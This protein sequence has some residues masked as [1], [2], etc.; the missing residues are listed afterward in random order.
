MKYEPLI[1]RAVVVSLVTAALQILNMVGLS[2]PGQPEEVTDAVFYVVMFVS[3]LYA[4]WSARKVVTPV[5]S[6]YDDNGAALVPADAVNQEVP[7]RHRPESA[8]PE[9]EPTELA[10]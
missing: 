2:V 5:A 6:P 7:P 10:V 8:S 9:D 1:T 3:W 4:M